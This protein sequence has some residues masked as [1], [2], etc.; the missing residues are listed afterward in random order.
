[1]NTKSFLI[2]SITLL[3]LTIVS[4]Q[5]IDI[6]LAHTIENDF[7]QTK[8]ISGQFISA[9]ELI[10]GFSISK[11]LLG[12][13][14]LAAGLLFYFLR[15]RLFSLYRVFFF[16]G[17][18]HITSRLLAGIL[19]NV[20][21][22]IRPFQYMENPGDGK[23]FFIDG[24]GSFPSGHTAHF[25]SLFIPLAFLYPRYT[26]LFMIIPL[27]VGFSRVISNDHFPG[28]VLFSVLIAYACSYIFLKIFK[29]NK[30]GLA[31]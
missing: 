27:A 10:T 2:I 30:T 17:S 7:F 18:A 25:F 31:N 19:K 4:I 13:I 9:L 5:C 8:K 23:T 24:G 16:I 3:L 20:F 15:Y 11:F 29:L 6:P 21:E 26:L 12:F 28:D 14:L 1:M 22:R